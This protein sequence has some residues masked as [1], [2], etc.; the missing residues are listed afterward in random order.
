MLQF[1]YVLVFFRWMGS[2]TNY[3]G[4]KFWQGT[5]DYPF[6]VIKECKYVVVLR[7]FSYNGAYIVI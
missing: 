4:D 3:F 1:D 7:D 2:T 5:L 6:G